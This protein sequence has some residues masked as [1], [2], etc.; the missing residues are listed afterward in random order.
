MHQRIVKSVVRQAPELPWQTQQVV[1][2]RLVIGTLVHTVS[3]RAVSVRTAT[4]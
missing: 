4:V 2:H 1:L 3:P